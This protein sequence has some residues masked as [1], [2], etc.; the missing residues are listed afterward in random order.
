MNERQATKKTVSGEE[1][2]RLLGSGEAK[3]FDLRDKESWHSYQVPGSHQVDEDSLREA[4]EELPDETK[5]ILICEDGKRSAE[6]AAE[7]RQAGRDAI[8]LE[9][10]IAS[11]E[12]AKVEAL[13][14]SDFEYEGP[15]DKP[16]GI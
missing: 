11:W 6:L 9:G 7:L 8:S 12:D 16:P 13:P 15:G 3:A 2:R 1:A 5:V 4:L 10:G 14:R